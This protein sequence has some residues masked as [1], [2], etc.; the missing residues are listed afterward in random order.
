[1]CCEFLLSGDETCCYG[2]YTREIEF[3]AQVVHI[4]GSTHN[5]TLRLSIYVGDYCSGGIE[6][7]VHRLSII[8]LDPAT[9]KPYSVDGFLVFFRFV[10]SVLHVLSTSIR[11][12]LA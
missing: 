7:R 5:K 2:G 1:M 12:Q 8:L 10:I 11:K 9:L 3:P 6:Q 4:A